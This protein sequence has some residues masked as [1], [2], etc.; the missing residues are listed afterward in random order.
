MLGIDE[1]EMMI[2]KTFITFSIGH[3]HF[4]QCNSVRSAKNTRR[5]ETAQI[6]PCRI[7]PCSFV[8]S[9]WLFH[10]E[11][12]LNNCSIEDQYCL[13]YMSHPQSSGD[14]G[15]AG[16]PPSSTSEAVLKASSKSFCDRLDRVYGYAFE[17][18]QGNPSMDYERLIDSLFFTG[19]QA[20]HFGKA[21]TIVND[22]L[23]ERLKPFEPDAGIEDE[24]IRPKTGCTIFLSYTSNMISS[25]IRENIRFLVKNKL[26]DCIVTTAG[27]IEEDIIK[28]LDLKQGDPSKKADTYIG[29]FRLSGATLRENGINRIGNLLVPN[30][31][32][33]R[34]EDWLLPVLDKMLIEQNKTGIVWSPSKLI[35]R[36]GLEIDHPDSVCY[37]AAKNKI[38]IFCP[39]L[40]DG[41]LGD[42]LHFHTFRSPGLVLDIISD[43]RRINTYAH[44]TEHS[45]TG[46][47]ILGGGVAKHHTMNANLMRNGANFTVFI[48]TAAEFDGS[49]SGAEPDEAISWGKVKPD[50]RSVKVACDASIVFPLLIAS[51]FSKFCKK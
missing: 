39:A 10:Q 12:D 21:I 6:F 18:D 51:T 46:A 1:E 47:I 17:D 44:H 40:T 35:E 32:Y 4:A 26:V 37:W 36:L 45:K 14:G 8:G 42:M 33:C 43:I 30:D 13:F 9:T 3:T 15:E 41:S 23:E 5:L 49:D 16:E 20:T 28:C 50:A 7:P 11:F 48:N 25:G 34:F 38:P 19:F 31:N 27:G 2:N 24:F 22:M 29:S